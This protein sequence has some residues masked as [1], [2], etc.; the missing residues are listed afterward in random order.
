[1]YFILQINRNSVCD[2]QVKNVKQ[3]LLLNQLNVAHFNSGKISTCTET[4]YAS[5]R[6]SIFYERSIFRVTLALVGASFSVNNT[7]HRK[8]TGAYLLAH[9]NDA[10]IRGLPTVNHSR[11]IVTCCRLR[12]FSRSL[13]SGDTSPSRR[14]PR[15]DVSTSPLIHLDG[16][17]PFDVCL[18]QRG[19]LGDREQH[20]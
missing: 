6:G 11:R 17:G 3:H 10:V 1:M 2:V 12:C 13:C 15:A 19:A 16:C 20:R 4:E 9:I 8:T 7:V 18:G 5:A 14:L